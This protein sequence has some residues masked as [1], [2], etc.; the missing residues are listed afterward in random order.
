MFLVC[1]TTPHFLTPKQYF[2]IVYN[3]GITMRDYNIP[4]LQEYLQ[5]A[6]NGHEPLPE[7]LFWLLLT[8][9]FPSEQEFAD[10]Q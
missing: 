9:D 4:E 3:Q 8:G 10:V 1:F 5:K 6:E 2:Y 7:A